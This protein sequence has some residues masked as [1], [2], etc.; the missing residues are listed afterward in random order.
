MDIRKCIICDTYERKSKRK[1]KK[2]SK[3]KSKKK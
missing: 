1:S 3:R 2:K